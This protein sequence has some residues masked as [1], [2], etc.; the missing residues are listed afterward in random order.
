MVGTE[1]K[2][3]MNFFA[4]LSRSSFNRLM[5]VEPYFRDSEVKEK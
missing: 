2:Q 1:G 3:N 4:N 5:E